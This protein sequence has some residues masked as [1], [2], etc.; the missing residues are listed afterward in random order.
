MYMK[1]S[2]ILLIIMTNIFHQMALYGRSIHR[3]YDHFVPEITTCWLGDTSHVYRLRHTHLEA[4][5]IFHN[6]DAAYLAQHSLPS[7]EIGYRNNPDLKVQGDTLKKLVET[8][9][10][11]LQNIRRQPKAFDDFILIKHR[12]YNWRDHSGSIILKFKRYPFIVKIFMENPQSFASP[13]S[14]GFEGCCQFMMS[15]GVNRFLAGLT[16]I[17]NLEAIK[18]TI[19]ND[20]YWETVLDVPRKWFWLPE[21]PRY[22]EV[23]GKNIGLKEHHILFPSVYAIVSDAIEGG[24]ELSIG[25]AEDRTTALRITKFLGIR[26]DSHI[27]NFL[28]EP[29]GKI[30]IIDT[31]YFPALTGIYE[32]REFSNF[33]HYYS[34]LGGKCLINSFFRNKKERRKRARYCKEISLSSCST[35]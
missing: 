12:N 34:V 8:V 29:T 24:Q 15:G 3:P 32:D 33:V 25:N 30:V 23:Y 20:R 26:V 11:L 2:W 6:Y 18:N 31:E 1:H 17:K 28:K 7:Q 13:F 27:D 9:V 16:R 35:I 10:N 4:P 19:K 5:T 21:N 22:F 14:K